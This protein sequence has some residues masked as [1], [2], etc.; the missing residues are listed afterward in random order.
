MFGFFLAGLLLLL[1]GLLFYL[2]VRASGAIYGWPALARPTLG[3]S[4]NWLGW[5]G[6][7]PSFLHVIAMTLMTYAVLGVGKSRA[8][9]AASSWVIVDSLFEI[10]QH[11]ALSSRLITWIP[12]WFQTIP[13]LDNLRPHLQHGTFDPIDLVAIVCGGM[14]AWYVI[15]VIESKRRW[16]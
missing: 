1:F 7:L 5:T 14:F 11:H 2:S 3:M 6:S 16:L 4:G 15:K 12:D 10:A 8:L 13:L 9:L